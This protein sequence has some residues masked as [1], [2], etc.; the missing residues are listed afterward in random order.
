MK[1]S[2]NLGECPRISNYTRICGAG[3]KVEEFIYLSSQF[4]R[5]FGVLGAAGAGAG[6]FLLRLLQFHLQ[7]LN[8][9][10]KKKKFKST[11]VTSKSLQR[12]TE[13]I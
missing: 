11:L 7:Q 3:G 4:S 8:R 13:S 2:L 5:L 9:K 10:E 12:I 1:A 6:E